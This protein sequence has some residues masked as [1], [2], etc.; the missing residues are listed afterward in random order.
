[1]TALAFYSKA[2]AEAYAAEAMEKGCHALIV[3][4]GALFIVQLWDRT[5]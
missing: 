3:V 1:M 5:T 4:D 2:E